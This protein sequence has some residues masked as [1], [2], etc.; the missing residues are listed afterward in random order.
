[1]ISLKT[2]LPKK[3]IRSD[4]CLYHHRKSTHEEKSLMPNCSKYSFLLLQFKDFE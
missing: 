3:I 1:M 2:Y 4:Y